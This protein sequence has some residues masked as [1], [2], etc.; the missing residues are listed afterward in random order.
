MNLHE[1]DNFTKMELLRANV[2]AWVVVIDVVRLP[3]IGAIPVDILTSNAW[4]SAPSLASSVQSAVKLLDYCQY[5]SRGCFSILLLSIFL[6]WSLW[7][8][9][10]VALTSQL[11]QAHCHSCRLTA[12]WPF[13]SWPP[14]SVSVPRNTSDPPH[15]NIWQ[16]EAVTFSLCAWPVFITG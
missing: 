2:Y 6:L 16:R 11:G 8:L 14:T 15:L 12:F 9:L 7:A 13:E 4:V 3:S 5:T 1:E 10:L